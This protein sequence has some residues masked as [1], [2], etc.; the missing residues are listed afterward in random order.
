MQSVPEVFLW[1][2]LKLL[3]VLKHRFS[4]SGMVRPTEEN[5]SG[6]TQIPR[7]GDMPGYVGCHAEEAQGLLQGTGSQEN[8]W[9]R[10]FA[11]V[12]V[13]RSA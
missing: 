7:R 12:S 4:Y 2:V 3:F 10:A 5:T 9:T 13:G 1:I 8:T 6:Y 11:V